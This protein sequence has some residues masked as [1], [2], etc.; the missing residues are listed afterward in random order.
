MQWGTA[1]PHAKSAT[2]AKEFSLDYPG[3]PH[4]LAKHSLPQPSFTGFR[5]FASLASFA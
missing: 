4:R 3:A 5:S 1:V 2:D